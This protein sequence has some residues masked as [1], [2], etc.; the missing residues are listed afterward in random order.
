M[1]TDEHEH[2]MKVWREALA[3]TGNFVRFNSKSEKAAAAVIAADRAGLVARV[4]ELDGFLVHA[5]H[6]RKKIKEAG[7]KREPLL[8]EAVMGFDAARNGLKDT[9]H[10]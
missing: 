7:L 6:L 2:A 1:L 4:A 8:Y 10:D 9:R 5:D 3:A